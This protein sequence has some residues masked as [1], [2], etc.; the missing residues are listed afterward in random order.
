MPPAHTLLRTESRLR[1]LG[2]RGSGRYARH[3]ELTYKKG[4]G[5][6]EHGPD[7]LRRTHIVG[8]HRYR[9]FV[10]VVV[11]LKGAIRELEYI[12]FL[13]LHL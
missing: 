8:H 4:I 9:Q 11:L 5:S 13:L 2:R 6:A 10:E 3:D 7:I 1:N 12:L